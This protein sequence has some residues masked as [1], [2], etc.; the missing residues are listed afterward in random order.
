MVGEALG[1][2]VLEGV[3]TGE[4]VGVGAGAGGAATG[5]AFPFTVRSTCRLWSLVALTVES[6]RAVL[7][8]IKFSITLIEEEKEALGTFALS[9]VCDLETRKTLNM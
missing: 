1:L 9:T 7:K 8:N 6:V 5:T 4:G 3:A 2:G